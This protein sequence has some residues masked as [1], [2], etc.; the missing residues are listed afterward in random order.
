MF[1]LKPEIKVF[2]E[3]KAG[4]ALISKGPVIISKGE[5]PGYLKFSRALKKSVE[6]QVTSVDWEEN[7]TRSAGKAAAGAV[8]GGLLTGG[9]GLVAGAAIGGRKR[10]NSTAVLTLLDGGQEHK[11]FLKLKG[12]DLENLQRLLYETDTRL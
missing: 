3:V 4:N 11:L 8:V 1:G 6:F 12:A 9:I 7:A 2:T 10:D 5:Q